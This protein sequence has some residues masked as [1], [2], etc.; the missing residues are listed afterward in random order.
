MLIRPMAIFLKWQS[1][2]S[3][4]DQPLWMEKWL[5]FNIGSNF[6]AT[7]ACEIGLKDTWHFNVAFMQ[8]LFAEKKY[9]LSSAV[10]Q[11]GRSQRGNAYVSIANNNSTTVKKEHRISPKWNS[12]WDS[13]NSIPTT[14]IRFIFSVSFIN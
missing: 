12:T 6:I 8:I 7:S 14:S 4:V 13:I 2:K 1:T 11:S 3:Y 5:N 10:I 9:V